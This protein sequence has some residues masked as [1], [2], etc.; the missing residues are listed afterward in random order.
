MKLRE[1]FEYLSGLV[2]D[3]MITLTE[4]KE[5]AALPL[6]LVPHESLP[7]NSEFKKFWDE[8]DGGSNN[9]KKIVTVYEL[10]DLPFIDFV[11]MY[12]FHKDWKRISRIE[13]GIE[14]DDKD[15]IIYCRFTFD[16]ENDII[17]E[18]YS[19]NGKI[20][21]KTEGKYSDGDIDIDYDKCQLKIKGLPEW[22]EEYKKCRNESLY[23]CFS[24][25]I[26]GVFTAAMMWHRYHGMSDRY[27]ISVKKNNPP[28]V[29]NIMTK[30]IAKVLG[31]RI[32]YLDKLPTEDE[33][34][35]SESGNNSKAPHQRKGHWATLKSERFKNHP[36]YMIKNGIYRKPAW[37]GDRTKIV[38]GA[39]YTVLD[40][41]VNYD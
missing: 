4:A 22:S 30:Q 33:N 38:H 21:A 36:M 29:V 32:I 25:D 24:N 37:I 14:I 9:R 10:E 20:W 7:E 13:P 19:C 3:K 40:R 16:E 27:T 11:V 34:I 26:H 17:R 12:N 15:S 41:E 8:F 28:K 1:D 23:A 31:P 2:Q 18:S 35:V 39:T 5:M 6:L